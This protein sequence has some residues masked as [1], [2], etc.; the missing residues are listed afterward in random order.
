MNT[1]LRRPASLAAACAAVA[2]VFAAPSPAHAIPIPDSTC[3]APYVCL[4]EDSGY[5]GDRYDRH[6]SMEN[7]WE[8]GWWNGDNEISSVKNRSPFFLCLYED[9][10]W[11]G[12]WVRISSGASV[13]DLDDSHNFDNDAES[14][15]LTSGN[16]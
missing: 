10:E 2:A 12:D 6:G 15:R 5:Y 16:C 7:S 8:L 4:V 1:R 3:Y 14:A 11:E 9:D 13:Y